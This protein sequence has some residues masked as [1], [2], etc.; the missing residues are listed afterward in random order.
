[1]DRLAD[2]LER[3][4]ERGDPRTLG[5]LYRLWNWDRLLEAPARTQRAVLAVKNAKS[6]PALA[7]IHA[8]HLAAQLAFRA[9]DI[10][11]AQTLFA[12]VGLIT[13]V[14]LIGPFDNAAGQGHEA[15]GPPEDGGRPDQLVAGKS[16][17]VSWRR[18]EGVAPHGVLEL[19]Y[20]VSP[21]SEASAYVAVVV[22]SDR[23]TQ[24]AV[25][26][27]S[28]D[29]L[30]VF[31]DGRM[32]AS[33]DSRRFA[34]LDQDAIPVVFPRGKSLLMV[35]SSWTESSGRLF[36]R[37]TAPDGSLLSG[38]RTSADPGSFAELLGRWG[39]QLP[40]EPKH[41][42][43]SVSSDLDRIVEKSQGTARAEALSLRADLAAILD[44][45]DRRKLPTPPEQDLE[46]AIRLAPSDPGLRFFFAHRVQSRDPT[47]AHEQLEAALICDPKHAPSLLELGQ[48]AGSSGRLLEAKRDLDGA[49][50][51]DPDFAAARVSLAAL[52]YDELE[53]GPAAVFALAKAPGLHRSATALVELSRMQREVGDRASAYASAE[54]ALKL[55]KENQLAR[56]LAIGISLDRNDLDKALAH[57]EESIRFAPFVLRNR[58]QRARI[59]AGIAE[60]Q[61]EALAELDR[62]AVV[63]PD[64]PAVANMR[65][66]LLLFDGH[67]DGALAEL[68]RS[69]D[70]DPHQPEVRRHRRALSG[71]KLELQ[72]EFSIDAGPYLSAPVSEDEQKW[73]AI[74]LAERGAIRLY[75]NGKSTRFRQWVLRLHNP[76]L[77]DALRAH[78]IDYSPTREIV[79]VISAERLR[80]SGEVI[81]ASGIQDDGPTGKVGGMYIDQRFK[82]V[83]FDDLEAGDVINIRYRVDSVGDNIFG[84]FFGDVEFLQSGLPKL[85]VV[86]TV[87]APKRV[88]LYASTVRAPEPARTEDKNNVSLSWKFAKIDALELEPFA[89][90]Y[91]EIGMLASVTTYEKWSDLGAWYAR[92]FREQM[93]LD[94]AA[95]KAGKAAVAGAKNQR[96]VI[97]RL[98]HYVVKNTRYVGIE[99]GIHGWKPFKASEVHRRRY[100]DCK[101]KATLLA[102]LLNDNGVEATITLVRTS[103][104][105]TMPEAHATMWAFN[106]AITYVPS[107]DLFLDPTAEFSGSREL[108]HQDQGAMALI[109]HADGRTKLTTLPESKADENLNRSEYEATF[110]KD[111]SLTLKGVERFFGAR[112]SNLRQEFEEVELRKRRLEDQLGEIFTGV[113]VEK[114]KFSE[115]D[116]LEAPVEYQYTARIPRY[117][118]LEQNQI[119]MPVTLFQHQVASAYAKLAE[120]ETTLTITHPWATRN[121]VRYRLPQG[122]KLIQI[123]EGQNI[124][125]K[126]VSLTQVVKKVEGGFET[127]DT[128]TLKSKEIPP[129]D[130]GEFREACLAID[131]ALAR[132]VVVAW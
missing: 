1:M 59:L 49:I 112:A 127:D 41:S 28:V 24:A 79:E 109:V 27:G 47:L 50:K 45:Y 66:E 93:E 51:A 14:H 106:H 126:H 108:P 37:I 67:R 82:T 85:D 65:A 73:G 58:L 7:R 48:T 92:L 40:P 120:R 105:G 83:L 125:S 69:L 62:A 60:R 117:G 4:A 128:V 64:A 38:V 98:Y 25:R 36:L 99:L 15:H 116:D 43:A 122:S 114:L 89:P 102:A 44:L 57:T 124:D 80:P 17:A 118:T 52:T 42:V 26:T 54:M 68:D 33:I 61:K 16:R 129:S 123:P 5:R 9:G 71:E 75:E 29:Q 81:Q 31:L 103:D 53:A 87:I 131:R 104:H 46:A 3:S 11:R 101:D 77:K 30:R 23:Q 32:L 111:S 34:A 8:S 72:D 97:E 74:F 21:S 20:L 22:D 107:V 55:D 130:Y 113:R 12:E 39:S 90:P 10:A 88:P 2:E 96:E 35:K 70:L 78:R 119:T 6:T 13:D 63:F 132:K 94:E 121:V 18:I 56:Q 91:S 86:H 76:R 19:S 95:R 100:G 115:L 84:G 110:A